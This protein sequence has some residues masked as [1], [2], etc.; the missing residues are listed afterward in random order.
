MK[1]LFV[2]DAAEG[3]VAALERLESSEPVN[4]GSGLE[5]SIRDLAGRIAAITGFQGQIRWDPGKPDGQPRRR[6]DTTRA[7]AW[8]GWSSTTS[9]EEGLRRTVEWYRESRRP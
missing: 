2:E 8:L 1:P 4:L 3:V 7:K 9:L 5:V 6:L